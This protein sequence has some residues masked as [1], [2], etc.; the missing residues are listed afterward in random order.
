[1]ALAPRDLPAK[2]DRDIFSPN[3]DALIFVLFDIHKVFERLDGKNVFF[4]LLGDFLRSR[5]DE[6]VEQSQRF[7]DVTPIFSMIV[8]SLPDHLRMEAVL[9]LG[10]YIHEY[11]L[12]QSGIIIGLVGFRSK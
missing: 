11:S 10:Q 6:I 4:A 3:I 2:R 8:Q 9:I 12:Q 1:M 5:F 7:V